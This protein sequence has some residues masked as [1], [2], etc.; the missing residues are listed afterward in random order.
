MYADL[1]F[2]FLKHVAETPYSKAGLLEGTWSICDQPRED[3]AFMLGT[4]IPK[5][6]FPALT[7]RRGCVTD[8]KI[9]HHQFKIHYEAET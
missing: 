6:A 8:R 5:I 3:C 7:F 2:H 4:W 9:A 1:A